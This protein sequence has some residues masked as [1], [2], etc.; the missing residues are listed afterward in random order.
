MGRSNY[1]Y[2]FAAEG[3]KEIRLDYPQRT[4]QDFISKWNKGKSMNEICYD[5]KIKQIEFALIAMDLSFKGKI[6]QRSK[7]I[8]GGELAI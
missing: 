8:H 7:G 4:I 5:L 3:E 2:L 6:E 1:Y